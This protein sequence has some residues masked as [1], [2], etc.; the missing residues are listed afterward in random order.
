[1]NS[2]RGIKSFEEV[3]ELACLDNLDRMNEAYAMHC[4]GNFESAEQVY[5]E[6]EAWGIMTCNDVWFEWLQGFVGKRKDLL[7]T[8]NR[9]IY[10]LKEQEDEGNRWKFINEESKTIYYRLD[11]RV[12]CK[13]QYLVAYFG[14]DGS[15]AFI[16]I[17]SENNFLYNK[18]MKWARGTSGRHMNKVSA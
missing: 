9:G 1:M 7:R 5:R 11:R 12:N 2:I 8:L 17:I 14:E 3:D 13:P 10:L 4:D 15:V 16:D 6:N 18:Y